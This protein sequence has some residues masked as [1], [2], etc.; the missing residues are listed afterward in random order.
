M[1]VFVLHHVHEIDEDREDDKLIGVYSSE[2]AAQ[3]AI[4]RLSVQPGFRETVSG[5]HVDRYPVDKDHWDEGFVTIRP[6]EE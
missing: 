1:D 5:F 6:G 2:E 4:A 3:A